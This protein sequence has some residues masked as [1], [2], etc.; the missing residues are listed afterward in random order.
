VL[1]LFYPPKPWELKKVTPSL[2]HN[3]METR[4]EPYVSKSMTRAQ[5][6]EREK[7][8]NQMRKRK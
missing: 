5:Y 2:V 1:D 3:L 7:I 4:A 6:L 8:R